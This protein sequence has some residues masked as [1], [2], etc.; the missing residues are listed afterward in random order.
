MKAAPSPS[1]SI[2]R[3]DVSQE[4]A[5]P[6]KSQDG[7]PTTVVA[8]QRPCPQPLYMSG[9]KINTTRTVDIPPYDGT[10]SFKVWLRRAKF[11]LREISE[12]DRPWTLLKALASKQLDKELD[13]GLD[14]DLPF[15]TLCQRLANLFSHTYSFGDAMEQLQQ[16]RLNQDESLTQLAEDLE[17]L[18]TVAFPSLGSA[19]KD[20]TVLYYFIKALPAS[21]LSRSLLLQPPDSLQQAVTRAERYLRLCPSTSRPLPPEDAHGR[22]AHPTSAGRTSRRVNAEHGGVFDAGLLFLAGVF[23][24]LSVDSVHSVVERS[25]P[26]AAERGSRDRKRASASR[27]ARH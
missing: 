17:R 20:N 23:P 3:V 10:D 16:R 21:D 1:P 19:D 6:L 13:A 2:E 7:P 5:S 4:P 26:E 25:R 8:A 11:Y 9:N 14:A 22:D 18:T 12:A 27:G 15:D 24:T